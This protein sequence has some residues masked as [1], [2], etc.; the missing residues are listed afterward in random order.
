M[1]VASHGETLSEIPI[2]RKQLR[3]DQRTYQN[4]TLSCLSQRFGGNPYSER[5]ETRSADGFGT[6]GRKRT[7]HV[8]CL[9]VCPRERYRGRT[10]K[11]RRRESRALP[12]RLEQKRA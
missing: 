8:R 10:Q 6:N 1:Y 2:G 7:A 3:A 11:A 4:A 5:L 12:D 9:Y